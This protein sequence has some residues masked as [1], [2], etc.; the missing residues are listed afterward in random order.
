M[1]RII[2]NDLLGYIYLTKKK[3]DQKSKIKYN[4]HTDVYPFCRNVILTCSS[5]P[6][7]TRFAL[8]NLEKDLNE[9]EPISE[10][11]VDPNT[12]NIM[13]YSVF[14]KYKV[15]RFMAK[16]DDIE[17]DWDVR[18]FITQD[19]QLS[20]LKDSLDLLGELPS[21]GKQEKE[22]FVDMIFSVNQKAEE[23]KALKHKNTSI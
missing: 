20:T 8:Y 14:R 13:F 4:E 17:H 10:I 23:I 16:Y 11:F 3:V 5:D 6:K 21:T 22:Q 15:L 19:N 7:D 9:I 18:C 12:T 1:E 2:N